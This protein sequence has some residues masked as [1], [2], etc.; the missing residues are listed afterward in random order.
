MQK[1]SPLSTYSEIIPP[2]N[3]CVDPNVG[4]NHWFLTASFLQVFREIIKAEFFFYY[5][6]DSERIL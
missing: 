6:H 3:C 1:N 5:R 4:L 2:S